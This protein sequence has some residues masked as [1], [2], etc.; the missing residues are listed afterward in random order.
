MRPFNR[1][2]E[3]LPIPGN[4]QANGGSQAE[5]KLRGEDLASVKLALFCVHRLSA[6]L[7]IL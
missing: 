4:R 3:G 1:Q 5:L 7:L 2:I 6:Q